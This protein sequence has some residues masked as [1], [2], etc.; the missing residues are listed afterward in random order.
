[1]NHILNPNLV[2]RK[3][4]RCGFIILMQGRQF[5]RSQYSSYNHVHSNTYLVETSTFMNRKYI[6]PKIK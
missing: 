1:M 4:Y 5:T 3:S 2:I 6:E